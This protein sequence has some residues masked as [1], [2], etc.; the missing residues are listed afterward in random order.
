M[1]KTA[2]I[3]AGYLELSDNMM[4]SVISRYNTLE[5][6]NAS[7]LEELMQKDDSVIALITILLLVT[8]TLTDPLKLAK[9]FLPRVSSPT[10]FCGKGV[11]MVKAANLPT[12][13]AIQIFPILHHFALKFL[14]KY[15]REAKYN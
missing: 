12:R 13:F 4:K 7:L 15:L 11:L 8:S 14:Q 2:Q 1:G 9:L 10:A 6:A 5:Q 3:F